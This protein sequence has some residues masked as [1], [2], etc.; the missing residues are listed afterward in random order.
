LNKDFPEA[1]S[2]LGCAL[3]A[4]GELDEAIAEFRKA[5]RL[6]K[7]LP[8]VHNNLGNALLGKGQLDEAIVE[9]REAVRLMKDSAEA[10][11]S[12]GD[13]LLR[14]GQFQ[15]AVQELRRGHELGS[16]N[17]R[18]PYAALSAQQ[19][20]NA[21]RLANLD[22]RLPG[23]LKGEE[24]PKDADE[25]LALAQMCQ[26]NKKLYAAAVRFFAQ[27]FAAQPAL[28]T[29]MQAGRRYNAACAAALAGCGKGKD[30]IGLD[31]NERAR[32]RKQ[33]LDW[34]RADLT[35][36]RNVLEKDKTAPVVG[37][38]MQRWLRDPDFNGVRGAEALAKLPQAERGD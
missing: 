34:L 13:A 31:D 3:L 35:A 29:D 27:A 22:A 32:L 37:Q 8:Q 7:D 28:V 23:L 19:L 12:L 36:W 25:R 16:R 38:L 33:A 26:Q 6:N 1:H 15:E 14:Q 24:Q 30:A 17:P 21:E 5:L 18:W 11:C 4:K 2:N 9:F 10:H 20:R